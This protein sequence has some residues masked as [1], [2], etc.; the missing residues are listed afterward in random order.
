MFE[1]G[2]F[3]TKVWASEVNAP[4]SL[5]PSFP[6][7][8]SSEK[9]GKNNGERRNRIGPS[10]NDERMKISRKESSKNMQKWP[11]AKIQRFAESVEFHHSFFCLRHARWIFTIFF[12]RLMF[13]ILNPLF[14]RSVVISEECS[15][16]AQISQ[17]D[18]FSNGLW[19][20]LVFPR[21][22]VVK[23]LGDGQILLH[24]GDREA[25]QPVQSSKTC[26]SAAATPAITRSA[27]QQYLGQQKSNKQH[28]LIRSIDFV[29][30]QSNDHSS[31]Q[32]PVNDKYHW[33]R[34]GATVVKS[35][36]ADVAVQLNK[37]MQPKQEEEVSGE[38]WWSGEWWDELSKFF[39]TF[40]K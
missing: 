19:N 10:K 1:N 37:L 31:A 40:S 35:P 33:H 34:D 13:F 36:S 4:C 28:S 27:F 14:R 30:F 32:M 11:L 9:E 25:G 21:K 39:R 23:I 5:L 16:R 17:Q 29:H 6:I 38:V 26:R 2:A 3:Y 20:L 7:L 24:L 22:W 12:F 8:P 18:I 15:T